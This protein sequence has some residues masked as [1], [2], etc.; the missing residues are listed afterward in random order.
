MTFIPPTELER[1]NSESGIRISENL[2]YSQKNSTIFA[3]ILHKFFTLLYGIITYSWDKIIEHVSSSKRMPLHWN[4]FSGHSWIRWLKSTF[5]VGSHKR[6]I[7]LKWEKTDSYFPRKKYTLLL[8]IF[9]LKYPDIGLKMSAAKY[10]KNK[11][12]F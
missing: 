8:L 11:I 7:K 9:L 10:Q 5:P 4:S 2:S 12:I 1:Q 6:W 3:I